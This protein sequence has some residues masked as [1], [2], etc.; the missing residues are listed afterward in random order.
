[1]KK[2]GVALL[3]V[4][5]CLEAL[6]ILGDR[7]A[8]PL[9]LKLVSPEYAAAWGA[10]RAFLRE[11]VMEEGDEGF[12][13]M[14][15]MY[16]LLTLGA[17]EPPFPLDEIEGL[18]INRFYEASV[19]DAEIEATRVIVIEYSNGKTTLMGYGAMLIMAAWLLK[20]EVILVNAGLLILGCVLVYYGLR[21]IFLDEKKAGEA[22]GA[23]GQAPRAA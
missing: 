2:V 6:A 3:V 18:T 5:I 1:M 10:Y 23:L 17:D 8:Y 22:A 14:R 19:D 9:V 13:P 12:E 20:P 16:M 7:A 15:D 4:G 11:G 21:V